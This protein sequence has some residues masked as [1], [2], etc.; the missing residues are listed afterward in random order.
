MIL[1]QQW[2]GPVV[3]DKLEINHCRIDR[4]PVTSDVNFVAVKDGYLLV[5]YNSAQ[6]TTTFAPTGTRLYKSI[7]S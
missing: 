3:P 4:I 7:T 5:A 6:R 2:S 1:T